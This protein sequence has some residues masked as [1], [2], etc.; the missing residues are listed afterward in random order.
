MSWPEFV[1]NSGISRAGA[2]KLA[3]VSRAKGSNPHDWWVSYEPIPVAE[4]V[5]VE[6]FARDC[7]VEREKAEPFFPAVLEAW[8]G[9]QVRLP[10]GAAAGEA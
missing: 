5:R 2:A 4:F 1:N 6:V 10:F 8:G 7:W 3:Q 9:Q